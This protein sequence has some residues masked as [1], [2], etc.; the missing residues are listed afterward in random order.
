MKSF[1]S[2]ILAGVVGAAAAGVVAWAAL[3]ISL[4][5]TLREQQTQHEAELKKAKEEHDQALRALPPRNARPKIKRPVDKNMPGATTQPGGQTVIEEEYSPESLLD[6]LKKTEAAGSNLITKQ[7]RIIHCFVGLVEFGEEAIPVIDD[8]LMGEPDASGERKRL[9][10]NYATASRENPSDR[11]NLGG[12]NEEQEDWRAAVDYWGGLAYRSSGELFPQSLRIGLLEVVQEIS[13]E[14]TEEILLR[15]LA[16]TSR[17]VEVVIIGDLLDKVSPGKHKEAVLQSAHEL[18][19]K[20]LDDDSRRILFALLYKYKDERLVEFAR[21]IL[22]NSEGRIEGA[23]LRYINETM[24]EGA[25][26]ILLD[27][28]KRN[29]ITNPNDKFVISAAAMKYVGKNGDAD[30]V[31]REVFDSGLENLDNPEGDKGLAFKSLLAAGSSLARGAENAQV[32]RNRQKLL[33]EYLDRSKNPIVNRGLEEV[34][35]QLSDQ[36]RQ[37]EANQ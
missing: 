26:P 17:S 1:I 4:K 32:V 29:D 5:K 23:A 34:N 11:L 6:Y 7:R 14:R 9:D 36:L 16:E 21:K 10:R 27:L 37:F 20:P 18:I 2:L 31:F 19:K 13:G 35:K 25:M 12:D 3:D 30:N 22:V 28:Y 33:G 24:G 15:E 8:F